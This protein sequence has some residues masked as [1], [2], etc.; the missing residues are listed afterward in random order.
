MTYNEAAEMLEKLPALMA[1]VRAH[2][3]ISVRAA[4]EEAGLPFTT[5]YHI[6]CGDVSPSSDKVVP[7]LRWLEVQPEYAYSSQED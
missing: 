6:E 2:R 7:I 5:W 1:E 3:G 4:A